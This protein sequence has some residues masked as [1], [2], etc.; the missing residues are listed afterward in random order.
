A[1]AAARAVYGDAP[2]GRPANGTPTSIPG[3]TH[4][5]LAAFHAGR[6]RPENAVLTFSGDITPQAARALAQQA[7]GDWRGEGAAPA[8]SADAADGLQ[9]HAYA[10]G[11][12]IHFG[13]GAYDPSS[14]AG[15]HLIAHEVAHTVQQR[16]GTAVQRSSLVSSPADAA[17]TEADHFAD[18][19]VAGRATSALL[20]PGTRPA[21]AVHRFD[22]G[23][24]MDIPTKHLKELYAFLGTKEGE[25]WATSHGH[26][27]RKLR[28]RMKHDPVI[29]GEKL[30]GNKAS[31]PDGAPTEY[32]YGDPTALMGDLF[33]KWEDLHAATPEQ[34]KGLLEANSTAE[35]QK[36][37]KG[38]Y[39]ALAKKNDDHFAGRNQESWL[40]HHQLAIEKSM[41]AATDDAA[42]EE[43]LFVEA[44]GAHFLTDAFSAGH[45]FV[46]ADLLALVL[47]DLAKHPITTTNPQMQSYVGALGDVNT[48]QMVIKL[49]HDRMN[50][51]GFE[52][53]ND[54]GMKWRTLGDGA[55]ARSP[56]T[57]RIAALA[58]FESRQQ[59][60]DARGTDA[61]VN[62]DDIASYFPNAAT[63]E[64]ALM[65]ATAYIPDARKEVEQLVYKERSS[66]PGELGSRIPF[67]NAIGKAV[68]A[69]LDAVGDPAR[70]QQMWRNEELDRAAGRDGPRVEPSF[71]IKRW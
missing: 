57:Q 23:E 15:K 39:L 60:I 4:E 47:N 46:K 28:A 26:D 27:A 31:N 33:G 44:A 17:E 64:R 51:E 67:G 43:A 10:T 19:F 61:P 42:F 62:V 49:I 7:F 41:A 22:R 30:H 40:K 70:E 53:E 59:V 48:A 21:A 18:A 56:E 55:L 14:A 6:Y 50:E 20:S 2:Y 36:H 38:Q 34:R 69:N 16:S 45:Q 25:A 63:R 52:V 3:L 71:T 29:K 8:A 32:D 5:D 37:S 9:A 35:Y 24:H 54:R 66:A 13:E 11:Q 68:E 58:V 12:D 65:Q 1:M